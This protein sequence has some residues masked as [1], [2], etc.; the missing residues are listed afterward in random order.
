MN[1]IYRPRRVLVGAITALLL[2][3]CAGEPAPEIA[4]QVHAGTAAGSDDGQPGTDLQLCER[5]LSALQ[6]LAPDEY[7]KRQS[8]FD[9]VMRAASGYSGV[10][11]TVGQKARLTADAFY[12]YK[13]SVVC[14][15]IRQSTLEA[16][17]TLPGA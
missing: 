9:Q 11:D 7:R 2:T 6:N 3:G 10:R 17:T 16:L 15:Q 12:E 5:E 14:S 8:E 1:E 13:T 4:P